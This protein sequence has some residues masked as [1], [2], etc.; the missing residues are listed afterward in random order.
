MARAQEDDEDDLC[1][2][3]DFAADATGED[4]ACVSHVVDMRV[5][6]LEGSNEVSCR[7]GDH[8]EALRLAVNVEG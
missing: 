6:Q 1:R 3:E 7:C 5:A 4:L 8:S 2:S